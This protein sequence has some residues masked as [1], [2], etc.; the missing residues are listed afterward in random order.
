MAWCLFYQ[1]DW[2]V[3]ATTGI[4]PIRLPER[5]FSLNKES[6]RRARRRVLH[7]HGEI[8]DVHRHGGPRHRR[9]VSSGGDSQTEAQA[10]GVAA[11]LASRTFR[12]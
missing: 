8:P 9:C 6:K 4:S 5:H 1:G 10:L 7:R 3:P 12:V 2:M 11:I